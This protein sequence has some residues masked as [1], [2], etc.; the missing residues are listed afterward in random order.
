MSPPAVLLGVV[1]GRGAEVPTF[2][3]V[4]H[5]SFSATD[6]ETSAAFW[7]QVFGFSDLERI[8]GDGWRAVLLIHPQTST[9]IELRQHDANG[10]ERLDPARTGFDHLGLKVDDRSELDVWQAHF[11]RLGVPHTPTLHRDSG[12]VLTFRDPDGIQLE[13][14]YRVEHR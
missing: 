2:S 3:K 8:E 6:A 5:I 14:F 7:R 13:L 10:G 1:E 9:I 11:E 4:S 12:S